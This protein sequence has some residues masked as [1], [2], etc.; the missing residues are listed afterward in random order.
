MRKTSISFLIC[1]LLAAFCN[2]QK[3]VPS[4]EDAS[5]ARIVE[6][7]YDADSDVDGWE[8]KVLYPAVFLKGNVAAEDFNAKARLLVMSEV[9]RFK[10][11]MKGAAG[12][13]ERPDDT[14]KNYL[15]IGYGTEHFDEDIVSIRFDI[16]EFTGGAHPNHWTETLNYDLRKMKKIELSDLFKQG[17]DHL[18]VISKYSKASIL[19]KYKELT[20]SGDDPG[21]VDDGA[22]PEAKN[23]KSWNITKDGL[24]FHFDPYQ[25][26]PYVLGGFETLV[27]YRRFP[28]DIRT[29]AFYLAE[30]VSFV[31][32]DAPNTCRNGLW[33]R[34]D[35][36]FKLARVL[37]TKNKRSY[38]HKD[39]GN[40]PDGENCRLSAYLIAGDE[41]IVQREF[42]GFSCVWYQPSKGNETVGWINSDEIS[43]QQDLSR[44]PHN[45]VGRWKYASNEIVIKETQGGK[46]HVYGTAFWQ[47][48][49]DNV[50]IGEIDYLGIPGNRTL[51]VGDGDDQYDCRVKLRLLGKYLIVSDN[52]N[53]GGL[54]VS[55]NGVYLRK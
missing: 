35:T 15:F 54:N 7:Q 14:I 50:H 36:D 43:A 38:F 55:F 40:C 44:P 4:S 52:M 21:W 20:G 2:A 23:F 10:L 47:G 3:P 46:M 18:G 16:S 22:G 25:V 31:D 26:G 24:K 5:T 1:L 30:S 27:P 9:T 33:T 48:L 29:D 53:C 42:E 39:E 28:P 12:E 51:D 34:A 45:W 11:D 17:S 37:G 19:S 8:I 6:L 13:D 49:G 32:G 41:L